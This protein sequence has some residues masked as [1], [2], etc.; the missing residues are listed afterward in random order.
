MIGKNERK[1]HLKMDL[2]VKTKGI[3][4][5][6]GVPDSGSMCRSLGTSSYSRRPGRCSTGTA[7][8]S[9]RSSYRGTGPAAPD[10]DL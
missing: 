3:S 6:E 5:L 8:S 1:K 7:R 4:I 9:G 2:I 10:S